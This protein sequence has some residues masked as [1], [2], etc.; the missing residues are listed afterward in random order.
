MNLYNDDYPL[1]STM[2]W[3]RFLENPGCPEWAEPDDDWMSL[4]SFFSLRI[5]KQIWHEGKKLI[6]SSHTNEFYNL[7][8]VF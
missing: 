6:C 8:F 3:A 4:A 1:N 2:G 7:S 5:P